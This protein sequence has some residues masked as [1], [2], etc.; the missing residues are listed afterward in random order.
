MLIVKLLAVINMHAFLFI[1]Q[2]SDFENE[3]EKLSKKLHAKIF[4]YPLQKIEDVRELNKLIRLTLS[5]PTLVVAKNIQNAGIEALNAFLKNL[6]EP[7]ENV[8]FALTATSV[9]KVLPT[10]VSRCQ[11]IRLKTQDARLNDEN[12]EKFM[13][14][15]IGEKLAYIDKIKDRDK[16]TEFAENLVKYVHSQI[17]SGKGDYPN[18]SKNAQVSTNALI[19]IKANGNI[20]LQLTNLVISLV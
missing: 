19:K 20:S 13:K 9:R 16:A 18:L 3:I 17:H 8:Y 12:A 15:T 11:I 4:E 6:E 10:V 2:N 14:L 7:Q 1:S 5:E